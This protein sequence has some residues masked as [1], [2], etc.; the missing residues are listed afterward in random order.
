M[1]RFCIDLSEVIG[2]SFNASSV[3]FF[4][5]STSGAPRNIENN[6]ARVNIAVN[7]L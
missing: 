4:A 7:S 5:L 3:A 6:G 2:M 1:P